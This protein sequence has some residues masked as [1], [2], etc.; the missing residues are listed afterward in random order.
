MSSNSV[1]MVQ[2]NESIEVI[3]QNN[4]SKNVENKVKISENNEQSSNNKKYTS[5]S[6][7]GDTL[8]LSE[9]GKKNAAALQNVSNIN[10]SNSSS[11]SSTQNISDAT[12]ASCSTSKLQQLYSQNAITKQQYDKAMNSK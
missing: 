9:A 2:A 10:S 1:D 12:L 7:N 3:S 8:E 6:K 11:S 4:F 5:I